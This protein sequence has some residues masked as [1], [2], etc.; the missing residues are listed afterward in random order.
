MTY[1]QS[2]EKLSSMQRITEY[3]GKYNLDCE[4]AFKGRNSKF[5]SNIIAQLEH[6][7]QM[8]QCSTSGWILKTIPP[9]RVS[10][11]GNVMPQNMHSYICGINLRSE[12]SC[13]IYFPRKI[14][15]PKFDKNM[16]IT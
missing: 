2:H 6:A 8:I 5:S 3:L 10:K 1:V 14:G 11:V 12:N 9:R 15:V 7:Y 13:Q 4:I 16:L